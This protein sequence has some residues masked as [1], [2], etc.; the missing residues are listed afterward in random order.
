MSDP[1]PDAAWW[2]LTWDAIPPRYAHPFRLPD[3]GKR[4]RVIEHVGYGQLVYR[5]RLPEGEDEQLLY[6]DG[7]IIADGLTLVEL[8][9]FLIHLHH[10]GIPNDR[11]PEDQTP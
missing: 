10:E 9:A 4:V 5:V 8:R 11:P 1:A 7:P 3:T 6:A 2:P